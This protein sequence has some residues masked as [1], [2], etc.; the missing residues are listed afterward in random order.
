MFSHFSKDKLANSRTRKPLTKV[1]VSPVGNLPE[2]C[3]CEA[4]LSLRLKRVLYQGGRLKSQMVNI[5]PAK[6]CST[7]IESILAC[8]C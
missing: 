3:K 5:I 2:L 7:V 4:F 8:W 1:A 6:H